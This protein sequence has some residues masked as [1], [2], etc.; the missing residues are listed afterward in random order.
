M[1]ALPQDVEGQKV[2]FGFF[3]EMERERGGANDAHSR[4][5]TD[6]HV[7][8]GVAIDGKPMVSCI[9]FGDEICI[10]AGIWEGRY[11]VSL[12]GTRNC[13][14]CGISWWSLVD[15]RARNFGQVS[16]CML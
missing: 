3:G 1:E 15:G 2:C 8:F 14:L 4:S 12:K 11:I 7:A 16:Y 10:R 5:R 9:P 6:C 13:G